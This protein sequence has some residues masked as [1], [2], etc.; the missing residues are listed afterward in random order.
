M[1]STSLLQVP[2]KHRRHPR[3]ED[4]LAMT[5]IAPD[6]SH[7]PKARRLTLRAALRSPFSI[8]V[9]IGLGVLC[10]L[11]LPLVAKALTPFVDIYLN[12]LKMV[13]LPFLV[14]SIIFSIR[15][16]IGDPETDLYLVKVA[17]AVVFVAMLSVAV[18]G[19]FSL[20]LGPG[21]INDPTARIDL[22]TIINSQGEVST[23]VE[24][25]LTPPAGESDAV[26]PFSKFLQVVPSN[27]FS[28]LANGN[29]VQVLLFC[30]LFGIALGRVPRPT[31]ASLADGL[32]TIYR[33]CLTLTDWFLW[34]LP[35]ATFVLI[36]DQTA[37]I[38]IEPLRLMAGFLLV[39]GLSSLVFVV[40]A[41]VLISIRLKCSLWATLRTFQ[42]LFMIAIT[43]R[44]S[45]ASI[46]WIINPLVRRLKL[47]KAVVE[48][49]VPLQGALLR[50][51]PILLYTTGTIFIA[52]LYGQALSVPDLALVGVSAALLGLTTA[53]M[54]GLV[55]IS[56]LS[57]LCG[58]LQLPFEAAFVLFVAVETITDA[59]MT[60]SSVFSVTAATAMIAPR[61]TE[62]LETA[63][64]IGPDQAHAAENTS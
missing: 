33:T 60:L 25:S 19:T 37:L 56:Q 17:L 46:P 29:T 31:S 62:E 5:T 36:A 7:S 59:F 3:G 57:I 52:Q 41:L 23:D 45:I 30:L 18:S 21:Q 26:G 13:V 61:E 1:M 9:F 15:S 64:R 10:G 48:L 40:G 38:G 34:L 55:I 14:S 8:I 47:D 4:D 63:E 2:E 58:Y 16:M 24:M 50:V 20:L 28:A 11:H 49:L 51:G 12:L 22:G 44:S 43:T 32:D 39:M 27:V 54:P 6:I 42:P 53:G 35:L